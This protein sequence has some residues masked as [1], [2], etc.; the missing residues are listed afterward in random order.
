MK[1]G[2]RVAGGIAFILIV[3]WILNQAF[4]LLNTPSDIGVIVGVGIILAIIVG[5][6]TIGEIV[7]KR[8]KK[9][10]ESAN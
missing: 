8:L 4:S 7:I 3:V 9:R 10:A 5:M 1:L 2:L 6:F